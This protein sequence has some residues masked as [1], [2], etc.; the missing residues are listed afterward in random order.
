MSQID[1]LLKVANITED[2]IL[3]GVEPGDDIITL[4]S[5]NGVLPGK[6]AATGL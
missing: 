6:D 5:A 3:N 1:D 2:E 4:R